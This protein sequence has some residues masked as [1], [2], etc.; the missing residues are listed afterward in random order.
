MFRVRF[1][2]VLLALAAL[3]VTHL[4][5]RADNI[6]EK[7]LTE[8]RDKIMKELRDS[9]YQ[10]VG[11]L[12]FRVKKGSNEP[13]Y[14]VGLLNSNMATRLETALILVNSDK[15]PIGIAHNASQVIAAHNAKTTYLTAKER[16]SLF[17]L[18]YP[19]AWGK[20]R[21]KVDAFLTGQVKIN[22][23]TRKTT[24]IVEAF[25]AKATDLRE[26]VNFTVSTDRSILSDTGESFS[27]AMRSI[28]KRG[29]SP[30]ENLDEPAVRDNEER[31]QGRTS[32]KDEEI[33]EQLE[34]LIELEI[35]YDD[36]K[37]DINEAKNARGE[38][39]VAAPRDG[40]RVQFSLRNKSNERLAVV[41]RVNGINTLSKEGSEKQIDQY[42]K[43]VLEPNK[44]YT[45]RGFYLD[46][47]TVELFTAVSP[48]KLSDL[49]PQKLGLIELDVFRA[50]GDD[51]DE[52]LTKRKL[53]LRG[54][55]AQ[56]GKADTLG[57]LKDKIMK[58]AR[59]TAK[60]NVIVGGEKE[61]TQVDSTEFKNPIHTGSMAIRYYQ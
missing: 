56:N 16:A 41:L 48:A 6:D 53:S 36:Q 29:P 44:K 24:V 27:L 38:K 23:T 33:K 54:L 59:A 21:V 51:I 47:N 58:A 60:R 1:R 50:A 19:L 52:S 61:K 37:M 25:D 15:N 4:P 42:T 9:K 45:I 3:A 43:W 22:P 57:E 10:N 31:T 46:D 13:S 30:E 7:L 32:A 8:A 11:V 17:E 49:D 26:I 20:E 35:F 12:K 40:A 14:T 2:P 55:S 39:R 28:L 5:A 18:T 34:N